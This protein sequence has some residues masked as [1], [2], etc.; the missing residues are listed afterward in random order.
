MPSFSRPLE[1]TLHRAVHY[2]NERRHEYATLEHLLLA[3]IDDPDASGV[4]AA[5][6]V[7]LNALRQ[8]LTLYVDTALQAVTRPELLTALERP[9]NR[10]AGSRDI[11]L[12]SRPHFLNAI[13]DPGYLETLCRQVREHSREILLALPQVAEDLTQAQ[14]R[15]QE[16]IARRRRRIERRLA[17]LAQESAGCR[18]K[19]LEQQLEYDQWILNAIQQP[20]IRVDAIGLF[21]LAVDDPEV[22]LGIRE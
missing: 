2:A 11:N 12:G 10:S 8:A 21:V 16:H 18:D 7:D 13:I 20:S 3:L 6:N 15:T 5:C 22:I 17:F 14:K 1:E 19:S 9:Y 4:M